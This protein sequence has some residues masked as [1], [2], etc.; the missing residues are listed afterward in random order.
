MASRRGLAERT[1]VKL[2]FRQEDFEF[3]FQWLT[4]AQTHGGSEVGESFY[5][6]SKITDGDTESWVREWSSLA[7]RVEARARSSATRGHRVSAREAFLRAYFYRRVPLAFMHP[8]DARYRP[9]YQA[10]Q[11]LFREGAALADP[12]M[13]PFHIPFEDATLSGYLMRPGDD[14]G[15][16]K[17]I[18]MF[19]GGD[20]FVED[21]YF[22]LSPSGTK[23]GYN[24][25][26]VDLPGQGILPADGLTMRADAE[27]PMKAVIDHVL[28][29]ESVDHERLAAFGIS[30]GGYL[31]PRAATVDRRI[32]ACVAS[33]AILDFYEVWT[34][35]TSLAKLARLE[36]TPVMR[37]L[38]RLPSRRVAA[39]SRLISTYMWRWGVDSITDLL[40]ASKAMTF[41][42]ARL[43]CPTLVLIGQQ[44]YEKFEASREWA[45]RCID[46]ASTD[47]KELIVTPT[48]E[49]AATHAI[50]TN[51]SLM[52][53]LVFDWL[54]ETFEGRAA[55][56]LDGA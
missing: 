42:P 49:G 33:S 54:D 7:D 39:V 44:E 8:T 14:A 1:T 47:H 50:G 35:N 10:A 3:F 52:S 45:H 11:D 55:G 40:E 4:G 18:M 20:T 36:S 12:V 27:T 46:E 43:S 34:R 13:E 9:T 26:V 51:L 53:Q 17:T 21:L 56:V 32:R 28:R 5:A 6:A 31:I 2:R 30:A 38:E 19:G 37:L 16:R 23:R 29:Y 48:D 22:Y 15:P 41:D 25:V 24:V